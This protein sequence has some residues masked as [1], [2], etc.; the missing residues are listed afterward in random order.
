MPPSATAATGPQPRISAAATPGAA[1]RTRSTRPARA[2]WRSVV[3]S[4]AAVYSRPSVN[5]SRMTPIS[6]PVEMNSSLVASGRTPPWPKAS[7]ARRYSGI[8]EMLNRDDRAARIPRPR[9]T[10]PSSTSRVDSCTGSPALEDLGHRGGAVGGTD[11]DD[12]V[13]RG[14][15]EVRARTR[16]YLA[17]AHHGDDRGA[18][19]GPGPGVAQ[20]PAV[21]RRAGGDRYLRRG[22]PLDLALQFG[23]PLD[24]AGTGEQFGQPVRLLGRQRHGEHRGVGVDLVVD[25]QLAAAG[26]VRDDRHPASACGVEG[27][28][29]TDTREGGPL[30][31]HSCPLL[32]KRG[33]RGDA[34]ACPS[35]PPG[36]GRPA[37]AA[38][39]PAS[40]PAASPG[41]SRSTCL[42]ECR[43]AAPARS[44][45][46]TAPRRPA[47]RP[48]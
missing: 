32:V 37:R 29:Q 48:G 15:H 19:T 21:V 41:T 36:G 47:G 27:V 1:L 42:R 3:T 30:K 14:E 17:V 46:A 16:V 28:L 9:I 13:T 8:G 23:Q 39:T 40:R 43:S 22:E 18:G 38:V 2:D 35:R 10:A 5:S 24:D 7:P 11:H 34:G 33:V 45:S 12:H 4:S 26:P 25:D 6:A 20:R 44:P 31:V